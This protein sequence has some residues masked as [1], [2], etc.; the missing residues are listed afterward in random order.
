MALATY[1]YPAVLLLNTIIGI[2]LVL[3]VFKFME[4]QVSLGAIGG[5]I[6]G[7]AII[8][9]EATLGEQMF[10]VTVGEMKLLVLAGALGAVVGVVGTVLVV[11]PEV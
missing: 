1:W 4:R 10:R 8:Y 7:A 6:I 2:L 3:G 11:E 5:I 9:G